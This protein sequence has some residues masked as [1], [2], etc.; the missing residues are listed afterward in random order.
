M[1][2]RKEKVAFIKS[3]YLATPGKVLEVS[4][5]IN[6][7]LTQQ[8]GYDVEYLDACTTEELQNRALKKGKDTSYAPVTNYLYDFKQ[9][10]A[11]CVGN[12]KFDVVMS[13][14]VIEHIPDLVAHFQEVREV[15]N[16]GGTYAFLAPDMELCFDARKPASSLGQII[17]AHLEKRRVTPVSALIDEYYYGV[18]RAGRGAWAANQSAPFTL[19]YANSIKL[20]KDLLVNPSEAANWHGHLWRFTPASFYEIY[21]ALDRLDLVDLR[22]VD[23]VPTQYMEFIVV[24]GAP[25]SSTT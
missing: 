11:T 5:S 4:P 24:L 17:E 6:P 19:K 10:I 25:E 2:N 8:D 1:K 15:L 18:M 9:S 13:S 14:H 7:M 16:D 20:I 22:L 21:T 12:D 3:N 23:V